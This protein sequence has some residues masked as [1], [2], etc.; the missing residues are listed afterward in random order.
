L[1]VCDKY[2][3]LKDHLD[4]LLL[5]FFVGVVLTITVIYLSLTSHPP[6]LAFFEY[7]DK[8]G[9]LLAYATLTGWFGQLYTRLMSQVW[10][11]LL[12][13]LMGISLE[14]LQ[15]MGGVRMFEYADM[16]ANCVGAA[17]GWWIT[18]N[19]LAGILWRFE[20][21]LLKYSRS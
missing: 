12:F 8:I 5:W 14:F 11:F 15:G 9:H 13:C 18:R 20:N 4:L 3:V 6:S 2:S 7:G 1:I 10:I 19:W 16:L 21:L 17:L